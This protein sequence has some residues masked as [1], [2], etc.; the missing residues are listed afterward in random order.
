VVA[1]MVSLWSHLLGAHR[2]SGSFRLQSF[3]FWTSD[4]PDQ[5]LVVGVVG[6]QIRAQYAV[7]TGSTA[8]SARGIAALAATGVVV[9]SRFFWGEATTVLLRLLDRREVQAPPGHL[10]QR[11]VTA[12]AGFRAPCHWPPLASDENA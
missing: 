12:W 5:R 10:R 4:I 3:A 6:V 11:F 8:A 7:S 9:A 1:V 2:D